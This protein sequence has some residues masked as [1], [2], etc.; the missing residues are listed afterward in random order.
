MMKQNQRELRDSQGSIA[1]QFLSAFAHGE[2]G[3]KPCDAGNIIKI[4]GR[5]YEVGAVEETGN[6]T[7]FALMVEES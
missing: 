6:V 1:P 5:H 4:N 3:F 2:K 7:L